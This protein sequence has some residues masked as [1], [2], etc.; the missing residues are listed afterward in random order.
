MIETLFDASAKRTLD[1]IAPSGLGKVLADGVRRMLDETRALLSLPSY[2]EYAALAP[3]PIDERVW[4]RRVQVMALAKDARRSRTVM[5]DLLLVALTAKVREFGLPPEPKGAIAEA[6]KRLLAEV[7]VQ[8]DSSATHPYL[9]WRDNAV[10]GQV[11]ATNSRAESRVDQLVL[12]TLAK[13]GY[14]KDLV[15]IGL[16]FVVGRGGSRLTPAQRQL[17]AI[18]R[19]LLRRTPVLVMDDP[20]SGLDPASRAKVV[21]LLKEW[22][23]D[24]IVVTVS[25]DPDFVKE[26]DTV[27]VLDAG[28]LVA[29]GTFAELQHD[30]TLRRALK[31]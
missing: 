7:S 9:N 8:F 15:A 6:V 21:A 24:R 19:A 4:H 16:A 25:H 11:E 26:A 29:E 22:K 10:Y 14:A 31:I 28:R 17:V 2:G 20:T 5:R 30:P 12:D 27:R 1:A 13:D 18:T 3:S 23:H